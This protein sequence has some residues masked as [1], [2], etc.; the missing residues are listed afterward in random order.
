MPGI[1]IN[2]FILSFA[3][4]TTNYRTLVSESV[5]DYSCYAF[6]GLKIAGRNDLAVLHPEIVPEST[7]N[8]IVT[9]LQII[10]FQKNI[11]AARDV[12]SIPTLQNVYIKLCIRLKSK[13]SKT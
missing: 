10:L 9:G 11:P 3:K 8:G 6:S 7:G 13:F 2:R 4:I 5:K 12:D 1:S